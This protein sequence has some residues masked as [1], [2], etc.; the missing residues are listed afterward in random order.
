MLF[1]ED[2][3]MLSEKEHASLEKAALP[4]SQGEQQEDQEQEDEEQEEDDAE[5][6]W[7]YIHDF[8]MFGYCQQT[9]CFRARSL[10]TISFLDVSGDYDPI[11]CI[12]IPRTTTVISQAVLGER[13]KAVKVSKEEEAAA[14]QEAAA[15]KAAKEAEAKVVARAEENALR[16]AEGLPSV[17]QAE[18]DE[19]KQHA[20]DA[21]A[22]E[23]RKA[24]RR[25]QIETNREA[26]RVSKL[27]R[28]APLRTT[29][30]S[31]DV[32]SDE[33]AAPPE[34][35][36][37]AAPPEAAEV[38]APPEAAAQQ[39]ILVPQQIEV[40]YSHKEVSWEDPDAI[41]IQLGN[42]D[43]WSVE[44]DKA[45]RTAWC[46]IHTAE[47]W[48]RVALP[49]P[50]MEP[51]HAPL[52][53]KIELC[54][55]IMFCLYADIE[56]HL[57]D[58]GSMMS[59]Q[60]VLDICLYGNE[61]VF[62]NPEWKGHNFVVKDIQ[63][64][65]EFVFNQFVGTCEEEAI[66]DTPF[67]VALAGMRKKK[68]RKGPALMKDPSYLEPCVSTPMVHQIW[69]DFYGQRLADHSNLV[70]GLLDGAGGMVV[71]EADM[72]FLTS[73]AYKPKLKKKTGC[74]A[75]IGEV[76]GSQ[77]VTVSVT[78]PASADSGKTTLCVSEEHT[79]TYYSKAMVDGDQL[80][81]GC[82]VYIR[83]DDDASKHLVA[84]IEFMYQCTSSVPFDSSK[85]WPARKKGAAPADQIARVRWFSLGHETYLENTAAKNELFL[86]DFSDDIFLDAVVSKC[87]VMFRDMREQAKISSTELLRTG[88]TKY[89]ELPPNTF[90]YKVGWLVGLNLQR[91]YFFWKVFLTAVALKPISA[92]FFCSSGII[93]RR[94]F[95]RMLDTTKPQPYRSPHWTIAQLKP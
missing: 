39:E 86:T 74:I 42:I 12:G 14:R 88:N 53:A 37:V 84:R 91:K 46:C 59:F 66:A 33:V 80:D 67:A 60:D 61:G 27:T 64:N 50:L 81:C 25:A 19:A 15:V 73:N 10:E 7:R 3:E 63:D 48:Y 18:E 49:H 30:H 68:R 52:S 78:N 13:V 75:L 62:V 35:A 82:S 36:E 76:L 38:A 72:K 89:D 71:D 32:V 26:A 41:V 8:C 23:A 34:A 20:L 55:R 85:K 54:A 21:E 9:G 51:V 24:S 56:K 11:F 4:L 1:F 93:P 65:I 87:T 83:N 58:V 70:A 77:L 44:Y 28:A 95:L 29:R 17:E 47:A 92:S 57:G 90:Y 79:R 45:G 6:P 43:D 5:Q 2:P 40:V 22:T 94:L 69:T 16:A 31:M